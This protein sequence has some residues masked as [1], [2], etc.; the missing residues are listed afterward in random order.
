MKKIL[1]LTFIIL[2]SCFLGAQ[3]L[4]NKDINKVDSEGNRQ[5]YWKVFDVN[6]LLKFEGEFH[7]NQPIGTFKY[8]YENGKVKA[9]SEMYDHGTRSR[10]KVYHKNGRLLA[11]GNYLNKKKDSIWSYYS[12]YDGIL[13]SNENY[14]DGA[15]DGVVINFYSNG[16][17]AEELPYKSGLKQGEWKRYFTDGKLKLK[18]NYVDDKLEGLMLI[19]YQKGFPEVSGMYKNNFKEG[20]WMYYDAEGM[21][22][23]KER[24]VRGNL[25]EVILPEDE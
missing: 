25:K 15:L 21:I 19:Y 18:A 12:D 11:E 4:V 8:Y 3:E 23:K 14:V 13:L 7:D 20:M 10:T 1:V 2:S 24:Y 16:R 17:I 6:G 9:V 5:G 22:S